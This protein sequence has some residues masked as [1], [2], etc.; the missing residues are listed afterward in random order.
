MPTDANNIALYQFLF[1]KILFLAF[2]I[3]KLMCN[4]VPKRCVK[5]TKPRLSF[6]LRSKIN[7]KKRRDVDARNNRRLC[8]FKCTRFG[9]YNRLVLRCRHRHRCPRF[10]CKQVAC[11]SIDPCCNT[12]DS[13]PHFLAHNIRSIRRVPPK[14][15]DRHCVGCKE[16]Q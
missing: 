11:Q 8:E 6:F 4:G 14:I 5:T 3:N 7:F 13:I 2:V 15:H 9:T 16:A 12:I 10:L 1:G